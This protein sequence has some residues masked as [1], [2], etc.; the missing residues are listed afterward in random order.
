[1]EVFMGLGKQG[2]GGLP[3]KF[4]VRIVPGGLIFLPLVL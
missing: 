1:M 4:R 2:V 3:V